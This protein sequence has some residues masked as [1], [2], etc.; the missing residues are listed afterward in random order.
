MMIQSPSQLRSRQTANWVLRCSLGLLSLTMLWLAVAFLLA[1]PRLAQ[2]LG[3]LYDPH[4]YKE[5]GIFALAAM[6]ALMAGALR[7]QF[8]AGA[9]LLAL[10]LG[11]LQGANALLDLHHLAMPA[12]EL[13]HGF[14]AL[15]ALTALI[16]WRRSKAHG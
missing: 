2:T 12:A 6:I 13:I 8:R 15:L 1:G 16:A 7:P 4:L 5:Q 10:P 3:F 11:L 9:I 14:Q